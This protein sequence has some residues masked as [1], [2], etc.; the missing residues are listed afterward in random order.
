[1][2]AEDSKFDRHRADSLLQKARKLIA[3]AEDFDAG[4]YA[5][6]DSRAQVVSSSSDV[7]HSRHTQSY[8]SPLI[9]QSSRVNN[10]QRI[11]GNFRNLFSFFS[12]PRQKKK[13]K[14]G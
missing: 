4:E 7:A 11:L 2:V 13:C 5:S 1:M 9:M 8:S 14:L 10:S 12:I 6:L 3:V